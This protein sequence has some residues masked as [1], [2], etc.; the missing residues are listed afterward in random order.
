MVLRIVDNILFY[1][2]IVS[3]LITKHLQLIYE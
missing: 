2:S 1:T 3:I